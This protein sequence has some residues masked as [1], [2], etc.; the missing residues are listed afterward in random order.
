LHLGDNGQLGNGLIATSASNVYVGTLY[1]QG[2]IGLVLLVLALLALGAGL[3]QGMVKAA[4][5]HRLLFLTAL[6]TLVNVLI[7]SIDVNDVLSQS[8][9]IAF[10]MIAVLP[11]AARWSD[12]PSPDEGPKDV[13][14]RDR[15]RHAASGTLAEQGTASR[16]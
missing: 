14:H 8:I 5:E 16:V 11:F 6:L 9:G 10:W 7:Q 3:F 13:L 15:S 1:D 12:L 4:G 2:I